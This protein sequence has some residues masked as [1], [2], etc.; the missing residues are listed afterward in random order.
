[1]SGHSSIASFACHTSAALNRT[2]NSTSAA[3]A[4]HQSDR[5]AFLELSFGEFICNLYKL[6]AHIKTLGHS[7]T[8]QGLVNDVVP[9]R[10][11]TFLQH[12]L[13]EPRACHVSASESTSLKA[14]KMEP[15][16]DVLG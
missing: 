5:N 11:G 6:L 9:Q 8:H 3:G 15:L 10:P 14:H 7:L 2:L 12:D 13:R 16:T 1:M 4:R